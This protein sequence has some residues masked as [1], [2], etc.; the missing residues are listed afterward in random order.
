MK[1]TC[2]L[3]ISTYNSPDRL[4]RCLQAVLRQRV[5]PTEVVIADDG[6]N[7]DTR[8]IVSEIAATTSIPI[9]HV[10]QPDNG[11]RLARIRNMAIGKAIGEYIICIDGDILVDKNF[12]HDHL[13]FARCGQFITGS[14]TLLM[15]AATQKY[16]DEPNAFPSFFSRFVAKRK[17]AFRCY[18]FAKLYATMRRCTTAPY[19]YVTGCNMSFWKND[20]LKVNGYNEAI[21]GWGREDTDIAVRLF[22]TGIKQCFLRFYAV[23]YHLHHL[24]NNR[25]S[26]EANDALFRQSLA[27]KITRI[28]QG[29]DKHFHNA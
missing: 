24:E 15:P 5:M 4:R 20:L 9:I 6:S 29:I 11:F 22:N 14:R 1:P 8:Q 28:E 12:V 13:C 7:D 10:W 21:Q 18:L 17:Y 27:E 2:S 25:D 19:F 23:V 3:I 16:M 26:V